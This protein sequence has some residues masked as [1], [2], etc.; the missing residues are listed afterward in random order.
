[1][2]LKHIL[3]LCA[4]ALG[5][6]ASPSAP[7]NDTLAHT[8]STDRHSVPVTRRDYSGQ[9]VEQ[10]RQAHL[11]AVKL[12]WTTV[13]HAKSTQFDR[14]FPKYSNPKDRNLVICK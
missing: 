9:E 11:D 10:I 5:S 7:L 14:I 13:N 12:C 2:L 6:L 8:P 3:S 1:M 4:L